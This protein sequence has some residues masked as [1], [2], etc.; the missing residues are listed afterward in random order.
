[1]SEKYEIPTIGAT[2][3]SAQV[4]DRGYKYFFGTFTPNDTLTEPLADIVSK[5]SSIKIRD[6]RRLSLL[7]R[8]VLGQTTSS[9]CP[10]HSHWIPP[11][12]SSAKET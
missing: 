12:S 10:A 11:G 5:N 1:M 2:A 6:L 9:M 3:S 4:Y 7:I 8:P